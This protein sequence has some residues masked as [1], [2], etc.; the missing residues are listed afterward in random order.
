MR[1]TREILGHMDF[2][3]KPKKCLFGRFFNAAKKPSKKH[4]KK[5]SDVPGDFEKAQKNPPAAPENDKKTLKKL[6]RRYFYEFW[7]SKATKGGRARPHLVHFRCQ[8]PQTCLQGAFFETVLRL[9]QDFQGPRESFLK[10]F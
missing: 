9:F 1:H 7:P 5:L 2:L 4:K 8:K 6:P 3:E 10:L